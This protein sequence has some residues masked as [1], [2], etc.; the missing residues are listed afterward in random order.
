MQPALREGAV[1]RQSHQ[2]HPLEFNKHPWRSSFFFEGGR[3]FVV[4]LVYQL[5]TKRAN[6]PASHVGHQVAKQVRAAEDVKLFRRLH[7]PGQHRVSKVVVK[8][9]VASVVLRHLVKCRQEQAVGLLADVGLVDARHLFW[10]GLE[11][12]QQQQQ[13]RQRQRVCTVGW[14]VGCADRCMYACTYVCI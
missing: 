11:W 7:H 2:R 5:L 10:I 8:D 14:M 1:K 9:E 13:Q 6:H 4:S 3:G 12:Q